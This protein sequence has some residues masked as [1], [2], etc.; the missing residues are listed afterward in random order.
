MRDE[1]GVEVEALRA[2]E[3]GVGRLEVAD[4][5]VECRGVVGGD[6]GRVRD[7]GVEGSFR[8]D[9]GQQVGLEEADAAGDT[10]GCGIFLGDREDVRRQVE[11][12]DLRF[13]QRVRE[14]YGYRSGAGAD[15]C[16]AE[17]T[18]GRVP[19][20]GI[21]LCGMGPGFQVGED[22]F[23]EGFGFGA[24]YEDGG[25]YLELEAEELLRPED[26]LDGL[27]A[28]T[29]F[30]EA[31]HIGKLLAG[32]GTVGVRDQGGAVDAERIHQQHGGVRDCRG[33]EVGMRGEL[34]G[35]T[36]EGLLN[37]DHGWTVERQSL[38]LLAALR[39]T[40]ISAGGPG[41]GCHRDRS[42]REGPRSS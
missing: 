5:G 18:F 13:W 26:L 3:E 28:E 31:L 9:G 42:M 8:C 10:V 37:V 29:A 30:Y 22:G 39:V 7:D 14:G 27:E 38:R 1:A 25:R 19:R 15:V 20:V 4:L 36:D 24:R 21:G 41:S 2:S 32:E 16:D 11:R 12:G 35:G 6:V 17:G 33:V 34:T 40:S 23:D